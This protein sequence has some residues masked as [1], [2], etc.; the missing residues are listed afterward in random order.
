MG[1]TCCTSKFDSFNNSIIDFTKNDKYVGEEEYKKLVSQILD[2]DERAFEQFKNK[3]GEIQNSTLVAY[4]VKYSKA[5]NIN[6][7]EENIWEP[8][9][10]EVKKVFNINV[11]IEN[12]ASMDGYVKGITTFESAIYNLLGEVK[13]NEVCDSLNLYYIN[14]SIPYQKKNASTV[15]IQNFIE[16]LE[17]SVFKSRGGNRSISNIKN[18]LSTVLKDV[19]SRNAAVLVSDFVFSPGSVNNSQDYLNNQGIGIKIDFAE[20]LK[21][22]NLTLVMIQLESA[23]NGLYYDKLN[24]PIKLKGKRPYY[25]WI[26]GTP[27]QVKS[28]VDRKILD[29]IK[30]GYTNKLVIQSSE[31]TEPKFKIM[32]SPKI[33]NFSAKQLQNKIITDASISTKGKNKG[34]F[35]FQIAVDFSNFPQDYQYFLDPEIYTLSNSSYQINI[36]PIT[37]KNNA[38]LSGFTHLIKLRTD[39]LKDEVLNIETKI[40]TPKWVYLSTSVDDSSISYDTNELK[41]TFGLSFLVEGVIEAFYPNSNNRVLN[42]IS[43]TIKK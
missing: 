21:E 39:E 33:G 19:N 41:K 8:S 18:V 24:R 32:Y 37:N 43:V 31:A 1:L 30:G 28:I 13:I 26:I 6:L 20:K 22:L 38:S 34:L 12:S 35:G 36:E 25:I 16:N 4:L 40:K 23:F 5:K 2:A 10:S 7:S 9:R 29:N 14:N 27:E 15:D 3:R 17:P 11:F 42:S